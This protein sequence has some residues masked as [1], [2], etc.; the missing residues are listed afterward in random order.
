MLV[1]KEPITFLNKY[2]AE[3]FMRITLENNEELS[4]T[5]PGD[6][7][8]IDCPGHCVVS[9]RIGD[10]CT[11]NAKSV[12]ITGRI[13]NRARL[14]VEKATIS[15]RVGFECTVNGDLHIA[16]S[17][18]YSSGLVCTGTRTGQGSVAATSA[19]HENQVVEHVYGDISG[20][21]ISGSQNIVFHGAVNGLAISGRL[22]A[23]SSVQQGSF[24]HG[25][26]ARATTSS[27]LVG[28]EQS[29]RFALEQAVIKSTQ[30]TEPTPLVLSSDNG[31]QRITFRKPPIPL[32]KQ[33]DLISFAFSEGPCGDSS[34]VHG[35]N[36]SEVTL[37]YENS[38]IQIKL[39]GNVGNIMALGES[40]MIAGKPLI[41]FLQQ[42][43]DR[44]ETVGL[45]LAIL[46]SLPAQQ[47]RI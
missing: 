13:G 6:G 41:E 10:N 39:S 29:Q 18:H 27:N 31:R 4:M 25:N 32:T 11:I 24:F 8:I 23:S 15:G 14:N 30:P 9:G 7:T 37:D 35:D 19:I 33:P 44:N 21:H 26:T 46:D 40:T 28:R 47:Q 22:P 20:R 5:I 17:A 1:F 42:Y 3:I 38:S 12:N 45:F 36:S 34:V 2:G 43:Q 16:E